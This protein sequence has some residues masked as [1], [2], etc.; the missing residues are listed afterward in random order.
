ML[1]KKATISWAMKK[2]RPAS[3]RINQ[4]MTKYIKLLF[5]IVSLERSANSFATID[6]R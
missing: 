2:V 5:E 3:S 4:C 6:F 1:T